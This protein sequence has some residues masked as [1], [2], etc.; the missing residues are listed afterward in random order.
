MICPYGSKFPHICFY[1]AIVW[2]AGSTVSAL[3]A[4]VLNNRLQWVLIA[5][6]PEWSSPKS[7]VK[8][9][10]IT[11]DEEETIEK[12]GVTIEVTPVWKWLLKRNATVD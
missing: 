10:I 9:L 1:R 3:G 11:Y 5:E 4:L 6:M 12:N 7:A 8:A 2:D